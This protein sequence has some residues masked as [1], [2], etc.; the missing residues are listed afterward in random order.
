MAL[1]YTRSATFAPA[2]WIA[3]KTV[4]AL[5]LYVVAVPLAVQDANVCAAWCLAARMLWGLAALAEHAV[6]HCVL[7]G[8]EVFAALWR[9]T[10]WGGN[11]DVLHD[12]LA[13][14][15]VR[16]TVPSA[17][18]VHTPSLLAVLAVWAASAAALVVHEL[19]A[20]PALASPRSARASALAC[21]TA[22][23]AVVVVPHLRAGAARYSHSELA[24]RALVYTGAL[25]ARVYRLPH[26]A[27][28]TRTHLGERAPPHALVLGWLF[29]A[30]DYAWALVLAAG[31]GACVF[32]A[33][34]AAPRASNER[35]PVPVAEPC[36]EPSPGNTPTIPEETLRRL[37]DIEAALDCTR[38]RSRGA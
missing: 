26:A 8:T 24:V 4:L 36:P 30:P 2:A 14:T 21:S 38:Q 27:L 33:L 20:L 25:A 5:A 7:D 28:V 31:H 18:S 22:L 15:L 6:D 11:T 34:A 17:P 1:D 13:V 16:S 12:L 37:H 10:L 23:V 9:A 19:D 3:G 29:A 32:V 35:I